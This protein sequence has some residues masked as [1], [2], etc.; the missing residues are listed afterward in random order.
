MAVPEIYW[1]CDRWK[2]LPESWLYQTAGPLEKTG[3]TFHVWTYV[4]EQFE[5]F[6]DSPY[7]PE[8][9]FCGGAVTVSFSNYIPWQAMRFLQRSTHFSK[10]C[11]TLFAARFRRIVELLQFCVRL[12]KSGSETLQIIH[13][14]Y[15]DDAMRRAAVFKWWTRFRDRETNAKDGPRK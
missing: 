5:I 2:L 3:V 11:C 7:Y 15:G 6:M 12:G 9:E 8:S 13:Q 4:Q 14:V 1:I 10:T